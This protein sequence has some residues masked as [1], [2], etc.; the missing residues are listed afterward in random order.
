MNDT[1]SARCLAASR[2]AKKIGD[3]YQLGMPR[4]E[5]IGRIEP[6][7]KELRSC[8]IQLQSEIDADGTGDWL[9]EHEL[10]TSLSLVE[11]EAKALRDHVNVKICE[12]N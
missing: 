9:P 6:L 10:L 4:A 1:L 3:E 8:C 5:L 11:T 7:L 2:A 12:S